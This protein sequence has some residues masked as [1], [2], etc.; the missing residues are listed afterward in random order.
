M[1]Y[2]DAAMEAAHGKDCIGREKH[3]L[4]EAGLISYFLELAKQLH[5][6]GQDVV[7]DHGFWTRKELDGAVD[8]LEK[9]GV[10]YTVETVEADFDTRLSRVEH[11]VDGKPFTKDKLKLFDSFYED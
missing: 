5:A 9:A 8:Y 6:M 2:I 4:A 10:P 7:I 3:L 1:H 11:R